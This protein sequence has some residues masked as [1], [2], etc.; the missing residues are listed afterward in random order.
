MIKTF[1][2]DLAPAGAAFDL[3]HRVERDQRHAEIR[4]MGSDAAFAPS[5]HRMQPVVAA[6]GVTARTGRAFIAGA[7]DVVEIGAAGPLQQIAPD[8]GGV[9]K[10]RRG[11]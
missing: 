11:A 1:Q 7:G 4:W 9:A 6:A 3:D 5:Q 10:L 8:R 2:R